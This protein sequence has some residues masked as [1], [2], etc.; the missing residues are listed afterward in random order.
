MLAWAAITRT[1]PVLRFSTGGIGLDTLPRGARPPPDLFLAWRSAVNLGACA[2]ALAV[3]QHRASYW[4]YF[5]PPPI[6]RWGC[7]TCCPS[8]PWMGGRCWQPC[9]AGPTL[10]AIPAQMGYNKLNRFC[11]GIVNCSTKLKEALARVQKPGR[12]TGGEPA[13]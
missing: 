2:I 5:L 10:F 6:W 11:G 1:L 4:G 13:A 9:A 3:L 7:S 12:Y 8:A